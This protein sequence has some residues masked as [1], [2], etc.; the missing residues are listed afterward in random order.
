VIR[1]EWLD[2]ASPAQMETLAQALLDER[3]TPPF[4][5]LGAQIAGF[6][7]GV[8]ALLVSLR[9]IDPKVIAWML[10]RLARERRRNAPREPTSP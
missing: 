6:D 8:G 5:N 1:D 3:V 4:S 2:G 7:A 9:G 10:R